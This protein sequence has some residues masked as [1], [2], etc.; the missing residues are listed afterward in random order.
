MNFSKKWD[1]LKAALALHFAS[2]FCRVH[3]TIKMTPAEA[4]GITDRAW[5]LAELL[6]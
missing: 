2:N 6:A 3:S 4:A 1:S 5:G